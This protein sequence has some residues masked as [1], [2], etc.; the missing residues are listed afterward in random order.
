MEQRTARALDPHSSLPR[1]VTPLVALAL[2]AGL[3]ACGSSKASDQT[4]STPGSVVQDPDTGRYFIV[5]E[6]SAGEASEVRILRSAWGRLVDVFGLDSG[7]ARVL[8]N[9]DFAIDPALATDNIDYLIETNA[10]TA[11]QSLT[12]L[13]DVTDTLPGGGLSQFF[14]LLKAS[15]VDLQP[16]FDNGLSGGGFFSM[17]PRNAVFVLQLDDLIDPHSLDE[18][19]VRVVTGNPTVF[20]FEPRLLMDPNHG[21]LAEYDGS[22][23]Q[24]FYPTR[25]LVDMTITEVESFETDPPGVVNPVGLPASVN[26]VLSNAQV[27]VPTKLNP[28]L[29]QDRLLANPT[30]HALATSANG[31]VDYSSSTLDVARAFR[32]G[33][34]TNVTGDPYNGFLLDNISPEVLGSMEVSLDA[35][36]QT[37]NAEGTEFLLPVVTFQSEFCS[38]TPEVGDVLEQPGI[39]AEVTEKPTPVSNKVVTNLKVRLLSWPESWNQGSGPATWETVGSGP[40]Q[41]LSPFDPLTDAG[42]APCFV[43]VT[44]QASGYPENPTMGIA[45]SVA[46]TLRFSEPMD[47]DAMNAFDSITLTRSATA[48]ETYEYVV[49]TLGQ[50]T[51]LHEFRWTSDLPLDHDLGDTE[52]YFLNLVSGDLGPADLAGNHLASPLPQVEAVLDAAAL[53][54]DNGGRV[55]LFAKVSEETPPDG[56]ANAPDG[57]EW[58]GQHTYDLQREVI[59][60]RPVIHF[61]GV[62]DRSNDLVGL[63]PVSPNQVQAPL[64]NFG[65]KLQAVYRY[66]DMGFELEDETFYNI[67]VEGLNWSPLGGGVVVD[68]YNLFEMRLNHSLFAPDEWIVNFPPWLPVYPASGLVDLFEGNFLTNTGDP[69]KVVHDKAYGYSINPGDLFT[70]GQDVKLLPYPLN[71]QTPVSQYRYYTWR[72]TSIVQRG[73]PSCFGA[74]PV[75]YHIATGVPIP[76]LPDFSQTPDGQCPPVG[77]CDPNPFYELDNLQSVALPLLME[78]RCWPDT[79]AT[80]INRFDTSL[81]TNVSTR[82]YFRAFSAGGIPESGPTDFLDPEH[83]I[84]A[85]GG[86]NPNSVPPGARTPGMDNDVYV[87]AVDFVVRVSRSYSLWFGAVDPE[88]PDQRFP[89]PTYYPPTV[90]PALTDQPAGSTIEF[91]FRGASNI[92][93]TANGKECVGDAV[94][95]DLYGDHYVETPSKCDGS[96]NHNTNEATFHPG[97]LNLA[98]GF[99]QGIESWSD[100]VSEID[101]AEWYQVRLT[102]IANPQTGLAP[103]L[104]AFAMTWS[105]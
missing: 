59:R 10:V 98:I 47:P 25:V 100:E 103:E 74:N 15:E 71:R 102:W 20:P 79:G 14:D 26:A 94:E 65:A 42:R 95:L 41:F 32:S 73:G 17:M 62:V 93:T 38:Q 6:S 57:S 60:A 46:F 56:F 22:A 80:A 13:R 64:S 69:Q 92:Q 4:T 70:V 1:F 49:G 89:Q 31:T 16:V 83:E 33:G 91:A 21:D 30:G 24:E 43:R 7:G 87:G 48:T 68:N 28:I 50:S 61:Q 18:T 52:S 35:P 44:P 63:M 54:A 8:M 23:G 27:R 82:P 72:D 85:N 90:V 39:F 66:V 75:Q 40:A 36:P 5:D 45:S 105:Q 29:G 2:A 55:S 12:I 76:C 11:Q 9:E 101:G 78:F 86:Y 104:S 34:P 58:A 19:T 3:G 97:G 84:R 51:D 77:L 81:A 99:Y 88:N 37:T 96:I 67:D 53:P